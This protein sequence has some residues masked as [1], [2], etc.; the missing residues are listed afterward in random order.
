M[1]GALLGAI[2]VGLVRAAAISAL[3]EAEILSVYLIV[4][5]ILIVRP[6]GLLGR[7]AA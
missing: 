5:M 1:R 4:I 7:A 6:S 3:P 2:I